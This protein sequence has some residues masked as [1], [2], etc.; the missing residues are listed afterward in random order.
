MNSRSRL[1]LLLA[2]IFSVS[3][4]VSAA[5]TDQSRVTGKVTDG[6]GA[7]LPGATV[8]IT[9]QGATV[10]RP[11]VFTTATDGSYLTAW[12]PPGD[13]AMTFALSGFDTR[14]LAKIVLR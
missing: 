14:S 10:A 8:T 5:Q 13:Y 1:P 11:V 4:A 7:A 2:A 6:S 3:A 12:L 9:A